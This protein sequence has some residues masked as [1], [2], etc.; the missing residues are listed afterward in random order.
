VIAIGGSL[1]VSLPF[2]PSAIGGSTVVTG[3]GPIALRR[4][5]IAVGCRTIAGGCGLVSARGPLL[6][7]DIRPIAISGG[8]IAIGGRSRA[9]SA[10]PVSAEGPLVGI[11]LG[12]I[13]AG[14]GAVP[15]GGGLTRVSNTSRT[16]RSI[17]SSGYFLGRGISTEFL[18]RGPKSSFQG[19][20]ETRPASPRLKRECAR[21]MASP[22]SVRLARC[23]H[24]T[25]QGTKASHGTCR[26][27]GPDQRRP[28]TLAEL[29]FP[30]HHGEDF[31]SLLRV[32][33]HLEMPVLGDLGGIR[34]TRVFVRHEDIKQHAHDYASSCGRCRG[35]VAL[36]GDSR[37]AHLSALRQRS[38][39]K[40][41][42]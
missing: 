11:R 20:R 15:A 24:A 22:V 2:R 26:P 42:R 37:Q 35:T 10:G 9:S 18:S 6:G 31:S 39:D 33:F 30:T 21:R 41:C 27:A 28:V 8:A 1:V 32:G 38:A 7:L 29:D 3:L 14:G 40:G 17:N 5:L 19:L 13:A 4:Q 25:A 12:L 36:T 16:P 23:D 34:P